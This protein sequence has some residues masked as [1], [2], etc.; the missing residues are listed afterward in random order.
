MDLMKDVIVITQTLQ[1]T[2]LAP[3]LMVVIEYFIYRQ[4]RY[5]MNKNCELLLRLWISF[6]QKARTIGSRVAGL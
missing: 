4:T 3:S 5:A 2:A 1:N 6:C